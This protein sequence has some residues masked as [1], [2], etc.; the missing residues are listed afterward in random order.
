VGVV[1]DVR[2]RELERA[3]LNLYLSYLQVVP[4]PGGLNYVVR[5]GGE[6]ISLAGAL[7]RAVHSLDPE[8][9]LDALDSME[10]VVREAQAPWRFASALLSSFA[11]LAIALT[12]LGVF[13]VL[14]RSVSERRRELGVRVAI[15]A[16]G[17]QILRLCPP[18]VFARNRDRDGSLLA[19]GGIP[20]ES[21]VRG[22]AEG[23]RGLF[24]NRG[25]RA[26][27][28]NRRILASSAARGRDGSV[29]GSAR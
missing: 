4:A 16:R 8:E 29:R 15:R 5:T 23:R 13:A 14:S 11:F 18:L 28:R 10:Q 25:V 7:T 17:D 3:R 20:D 26:R 21:A 22:G 19:R 9:P 24:G 27:G 1:E 6:P 12:A 2:Y